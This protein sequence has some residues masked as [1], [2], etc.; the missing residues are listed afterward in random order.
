LRR[1]THLLLLS[2]SEGS[3]AKAT[4]QDPELYQPLLEQLNSKKLSVDKAFN[5]IKKEEIYN[6]MLVYYLFL[7]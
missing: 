5:T 6:D 4:E 7:Q 2:L 1:R 3:T